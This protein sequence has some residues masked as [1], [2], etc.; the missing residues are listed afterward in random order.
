M[1]HE[2]L[3]FPLVLNRQLIS[4][5]KVEY[6]FEPIYSDIQY[7]THFGIYGDFIGEIDDNGKTGFLVEKMNFRLQNYTGDITMGI[8]KVVDYKDKKLPS[9]FMLEGFST[10]RLIKIYMILQGFNKEFKGSLPEEPIE[11]EPIPPALNLKLYQ[12]DVIEVVVFYEHVDNKYSKILEKDSEIRNNECL[13]ADPLY[14]YRDGE[15][16]GLLKD[17]QTR[18]ELINA[19]KEEDGLNKAKRMAKEKNITQMLNESYVEGDEEDLIFAAIGAGRPCKMKLSDVY[20][21][22]K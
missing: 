13:F 6:V 18:I 14:L 8:K 20:I 4:E 9:N 16:V 12:G 15:E 1:A 21:L 19:L 10:G 5:S 2:R 3:R 22:P 17:S 11:G 7:G